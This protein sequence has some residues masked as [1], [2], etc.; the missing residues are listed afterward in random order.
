M[1]DQ[2]KSEEQGQ[3]NKSELKC[4]LSQLRS[5]LKNDSLAHKFVT[6]RLDSKSSG[7]VLSDIING[8]LPSRVLNGQSFLQDFSFNRGCPDNAHNNACG[9]IRKFCGSRKRGSHSQS[10]GKRT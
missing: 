9:D 8:S 6:A 4:N 3:K 10:Q 2:K 5:Y 7:T 1:I